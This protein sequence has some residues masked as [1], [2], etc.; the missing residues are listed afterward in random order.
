MKET[1][2]DKG[3]LS[4]EDIMKV[5]GSIKAD[6]PDALAVYVAERDGKFELVTVKL[7]ELQN[8]P[9]YKEVINNQQLLRDIIEKYTGD[10]VAD[11]HIDVLARDRMN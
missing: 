11:E 3:N 4:K 2:L 1:I 7:P 10:K 5:A 8:W 6:W 9:E